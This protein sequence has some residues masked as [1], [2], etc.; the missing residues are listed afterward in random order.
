MDLTRI[1]D[2]FRLDTTSTGPTAQDEDARLIAECGARP[3]G[4]AWTVQGDSDAWPWLACADCPASGDAVY[5][6]IADLLNSAEYELGG[7]TI[8]FGEDLPDDET[9]VFEIPVNVRVEEHRYTSMDS[10]G[11]EYDV[12]I[13]ITDRETAA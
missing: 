13:H 5:P 3:A 1:D 6:D 10:I 12:E 7:R 4:H 2:P 9:S 8:R 11:Y